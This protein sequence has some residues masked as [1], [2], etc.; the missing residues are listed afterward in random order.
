MSRLRVN[1]SI[2]LVA[3]N[4]ACAGKA[5]D[6]N[7][8]A[9]RDKPRFYV[10]AALGKAHLNVDLASTGA[11]PLVL[12][13]FVNRSPPD[14]TTGWKLTA[15]FRPVRVVGVEL[16]YADFG[17]A[18]IPPP[19]GNGIIRTHVDMETSADAIMLAA[20]LF[21]PLRSPALD[22]YGKVGVAKLD[23][24]FQVHALVSDPPCTPLT[25]TNF[26]NSGHNTGSH[27]YFGVGFRHEITRAIALRLEYEAIDRDSGDDTEMWSVGL[28]WEH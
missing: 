27:P 21:V 1:A 5:Q 19:T 3:L 24:S 18:E 16:G 7:G 8:T 25:C 20:V 14:S 10:G 15:G 12:D 6:E 23:E 4:L 26:S 17:E 13:R 22:V 9:D 2:A 11:P 28:A